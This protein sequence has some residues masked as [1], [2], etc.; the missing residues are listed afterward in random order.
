MKTLHNHTHSSD[1][2]F[3]TRK[4]VFIHP[5]IKRTADTLAHSEWGGNNLDDLKKRILNNYKTVVA[6]RNIFIA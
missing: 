1:I 6:Q 2:S 3:E 4:K 5:W